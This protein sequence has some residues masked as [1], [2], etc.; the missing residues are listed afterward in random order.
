M[1]AHIYI[2]TGD[3]EDSEKT[4]V[5]A[6]LA[7]EAY[8]ALAHPKGVYP[9]MYYSHNLHFVAVENAFMGNYAR[10][11]DY[12][13]RAQQFVGPHVQD[14][15]SLDVFYAL[16]LQVMVRFHKWSDILAE[17]QPDQSHPMTLEVWHFAR[18]LADANTGKLDEARAELAT[19]HA[20]M[21]A[22][23]KIFLSAQGPHN[24]KVIPEIMADLAEANIT[25]AQLQ[26]EASVGYLRNAVL[27]EDSL[28]YD[29]PPDWIYPLR[30]PLGAALLAAGKAS[31]AESVFREDL[32]HN[33]RNPRSLFGLSESLKAQGKAAEAQAVQK[34]FEESWKN[35]DTKIDL[36]D[37]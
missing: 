3:H 25:A 13:R 9:L 22:T 34:Q 11:L 33:P 30:E 16:P 14:M 17:P 35:A 1:P 31:E 12:A 27:L 37:L 2:R 15:N 20:L 10:S 24:G 29:E 8:F 4:N 7:D 19:F 21:P 18:A 28:E 32:K 36:S 5:A 6:A 23:A 26:H